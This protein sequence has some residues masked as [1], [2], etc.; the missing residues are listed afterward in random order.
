MSRNRYLIFTVISLTVMLV[1]AFYP[2]DRKRI[3]KIIRDCVDSV[4]NE[5]ADQLM[6]HISFNFKGPHGGSYLQLKK[7][8]E[9]IFE[10]FDDFDITSDIMNISI[11][12]KQA[13]ADLKASVIA[14]EGIDRTY[15]IGDAGSNEDIKV[16]LE[17]SPYEWKVIGFERLHNR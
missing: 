2:S 12:G 16:F 6:E 15:F 10:R 9:R 14:S 4:V 13:E 7:R 1:F 8:V 17:K 5:N 11:E 3:K